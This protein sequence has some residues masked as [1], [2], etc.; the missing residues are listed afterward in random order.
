MYSLIEPV[1]LR[2]SSDVWLFLAIGIFGGIGVLCLIA[3]YRMVEPSQIT[4][5]EYFSIPISFFLGWYFF[6][7]APLEKLFPGV[8][9]IILSGLIIIWRENYQKNR[10]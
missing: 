8:L 6:G 9:V 10:V 3:C 7:E 1:P 2:Y 4:P 5:F